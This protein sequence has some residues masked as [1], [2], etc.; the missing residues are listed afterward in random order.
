M[1]SVR[2]LLILSV[3]TTGAVAGCSS[4]TTDQFAPLALSL[5]LSPTI[6]TIFV[7]DLIVDA[8][9]TSLTLTAES[10]G[11]RVQTPSG[12]EWSSADTSVAVVTSGGAVHA[13]GIGETTI[14]A[15]V[16]SSRATATIVVAYRARTISIN[17][18]SLVGI[19]GDTVQ[20][21]AS[22]VDVKGVLVPN[23]K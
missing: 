4:D 3:L 10:L 17:P 16:N 11:H 20:V 21:T 8:D 1:R 5:S 14:S 23:T 2:R 12:V 19:A 9:A 22:A 7:A 18:T 6:D 13:V 15:R